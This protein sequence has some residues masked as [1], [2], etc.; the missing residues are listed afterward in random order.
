MRIRSHEREGGG[1]PYGGNAG[2]VLPTHRLPGG[3]GPYRH[4]TIAGAL[5]SIVDTPEEAAALDRPPL[6]IRR[7]LE[8]FLDEHGLGERRAPGRSGRRRALQRHLPDPPRR[9]RVGA[10]APAAPAAAALGARRAARGVPVARA[11]RARAVRVPTRAR[12]CDDDAVIGAP[13]Y[14]ME[15]IDGRRADRRRSRTASKPDA[16]RRGAGRRARRGPRTSTGAPA[17]WRATASR[18]ATSNASCGASPGSGSTTR[19]AR[20]PRSTRSPPG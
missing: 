8:A 7:P 12:P 19:R 11:A 9:R 5:T 18:R 13:F 4:I 6:L 17:G 15:R 14:V 2:S 3:R 20:S 10:A 16:D 1:R